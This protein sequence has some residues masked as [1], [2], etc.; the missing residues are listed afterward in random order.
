LGGRETVV[1]MTTLTGGFGG[2]EICC[3]L[4]GGI[5]AIGLEFGRVDFNEMGGPRSRGHSTFTLAQAYSAELRERFME[6]TGGILRCCDLQEQHFGK[7]LTPVE[8]KDPMQLERLRCGELFSMWSTYACELVAL[9]AE[10][11]AEI[12]LRARRKHGITSPL[13]AFPWYN[14]V[15]EQRRMTE[16]Q[17]PETED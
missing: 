1:A 2:G 12:I 7:S 5:A 8:R 17:K 11:T 3:A 14:R 6:R 4:V 9:A 13:M 15:W 10:I 16:L